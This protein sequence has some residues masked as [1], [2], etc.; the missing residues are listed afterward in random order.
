M[1]G[2]ILAGGRGSRLWPLTNVVSKQL[3][4]IYDK[5]MIYYP[6]SL[7]L[8]AGIREILIITTIFDLPLYQKLLGDGKDIGVRFTY[9]IQAEPRG[10]VD[11]FIIGEKFID[12]EPICLILGDNIFFGQDLSGI[13]MES[14]KLQDGALIYAYPVKNPS[15]YGVVEFDSSGKVISLEEKPIIPKS[16]YAVPGIYFYDNTVVQKSKLIKPSDRNELEITSLN[17]MYLSE[18]KLE[19]KVLGRGFAWLDTGTIDAMKS[20][21]EFVEAI[22]KRQGLYISCIEEISWRKGFITLDMLKELGLKQS[23]SEYGKY[24]SSLVEDFKKKGQ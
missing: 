17:K 10:I 1:K 24:I 15:E 19:V 4:P 9:E 16:N 5:P 8:L 11:A 22:Q 2:I 14:V 12:N 7:L 18:G 6:L 20:A 21:S 13:L 3:L 23:N